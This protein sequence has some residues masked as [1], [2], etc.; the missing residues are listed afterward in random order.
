MFPFNV[1]FAT[2]SDDGEQRTELRNVVELT[3]TQMEGVFRPDDDWK[4]SRFQVVRTN[5]GWA[6]VPFMKPGT[7][8]TGTVMPWPK[9]RE[10]QDW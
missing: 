3:D 1:V 7:K 8:V 6:G 9:P 2:R 5:V 4:E 10:K